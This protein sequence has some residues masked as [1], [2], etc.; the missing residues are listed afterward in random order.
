MTIKWKT[1]VKGLIWE[2]IGVGALFVY[3]WITT[4]NI[5]TAS[6][7]GIGY[8]VFRAVIWYPYER[9][10]KAIVRKWHVKDTVYEVQKYREDPK[11]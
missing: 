8:P 11:S 9:C 1:L 3:T 5:A 4:G 2:L 7:I 10:F 6:A